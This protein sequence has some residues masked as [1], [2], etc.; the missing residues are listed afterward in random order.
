MAIWLKMK[1]PCEIRRLDTQ[2]TQVPHIFTDFR[3]AGSDGQMA[4]KRAT[5]PPT[6]SPQAGRGLL[7]LSVYGE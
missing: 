6:P 4:K 2:M 3:E 1:N 5:P 7:P